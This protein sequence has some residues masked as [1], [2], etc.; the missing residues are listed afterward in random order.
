M[1]G[2]IKGDLVA[3]FPIAR[4]HSPRGELHELRFK[5]NG[6]SIPCPMECS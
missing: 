3:Q 4:E 1:I 2:G 6:G 5:M